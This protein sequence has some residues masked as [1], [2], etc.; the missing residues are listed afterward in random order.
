MISR[1]KVVAVIPAR[2]GSKGLPGKNIVD[3]C[4]KPLVAYTIEAALRSRYIDRVLVTTDDRRIAEVSKRFGAEVPFMRPKY[5]AKDTTHTPPVIEHAIRFIERDDYRADFIVTLQPTS[6]LRS[7][8]HIDGAV[9]LLY[10]SRF[11]SVMSVKDAEYPP[12]WVVKVKRKRAYPFVDGDT[13]YFRKERQ[14]L[15]KTYQPNGAVYVTRRN[16]LLEEGLIISKNCGVIAMDKTSSLDVD[17]HEDLK[18][19]RKVMKGAVR[20][21]AE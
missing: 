12:Y 11:G 5:L 2:G 14:Q 21:R 7:V 10:N 19:I 4:G 15:P 20:R 17:T 8:A 6:P 3:L 13:D 18:R 16:T 9:K 1:F